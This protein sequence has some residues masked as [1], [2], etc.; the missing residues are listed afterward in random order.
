MGSLAAGGAAAM[1]TGAF[2]SVQATRTV[3]VSTAG[4]TGAY[5]QMDPSVGENSSYAGWDSDGDEV[6]VTL[7]SVNKDAKSDF[8]N[9]FQVKNQGTQDVV[10]YV[11]PDPGK[12]VSPESVTAEGLPSESREFPSPGSGVGDVY[13][14]PQATGMPNEPDT[15]SLT[16]VYGSGMPYKILNHRTD[17]D[18]SNGAPNSGNQHPGTALSDR[19]LGTGESF[20]FGLNVQHAEPAEF[21]EDISVTLSADAQLTP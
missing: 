12:G 5:L 18:P 21:P 11:H 6:V 3:N 1:G 4:D 9:L 16:G 8:L 17:A 20:T 15:F 19:V 7:D 2:T 10:V 13:I 14:D